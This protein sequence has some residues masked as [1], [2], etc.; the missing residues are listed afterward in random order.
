MDEN[1]GDGPLN[2]LF[3]FFGGLLVL[4]LVTALVAPSFIEWGNYRAQFE[5]Q[6]GKVLGQKVEV[7][8]EAKARLLPLPRIIFTNVRVGGSED[9]EPMMVVDRFRVD[10]ELAPLLKGEV[11]IVDMEL[12]NPKVN[13]A[14]GKD[15]VVDWTDRKTS[16]VKLEDVQLER[17]SISGG[18]I[19][20]RNIATDQSFRADDINV[21]ISARTLAGPWRING[22]LVLE[23]EK[24]DVKITT[25]R[26]HEDGLINTRLSIQPYAHPYAIELDGPIGMV[27]GTLNYKGA[28]KLKAEQPRKVLADGKPARS[29]PYVALPIRV[30][31]RFDAKPNALRVQEFKLSVGS[32][33]DPYSITGTAQ[34]AFGDR[35][36]F[37]IVAEGQQ[38]DIDRMG[39]LAKSKGNPPSL[40][41][42]LDVLRKIA[43]KVPAPPAE[44][45]ISLY[46]PAVIAGDTV[47]REVGVDIRP[48]K[49]GWQLS[50]LEAGLPG[51]TTLQ[52]NGLLTLGENFGFA[53]QLLLASRQ[54]SGFAGW[55]K[56]DVSE[57]I[58]R[59]PNAGFSANV[60]LNEKRVLLQDLEI[61]LGDT[62]LKGAFERVQHTNS[63]PLMTTILDGNNID[64]ETMQAL[65]SLFLSG[66]KGGPL[67][68]HDMDIKL[69]AENFSA[70]GIKAKAVSAALR[71]VDD[72]LTIDALTIGDLSGAE[73][74]LQGTIKD[75]FKL[76]D[77][78]MKVS[79]KAA[80]PEGVLGLVSRFAGANPLLDNLRNEPSLARDLVLDATLQASAEGGQAGLVLDLKG[81]AAGTGI[82]LEVNVDG[83]I[84]ELLTAKNTVHLTLI[85]QQPFVLLRQ[86]AVPVLPVDVAGEMRIDAGFK[87]IAGERGDVEFTVLLEDAKLSGKGEIDH[88][89][90]GNLRSRFSVAFKSGDIDPLLLLSGYAFPGMN[91]GAAVDLRGDFSTDGSIVSIRN[92]EGM[93]AGQKIDGK[94]SI[95]RAAKPRPRVAGTLSLEQVS[96]RFVAGLVMGEAATE[97]ARPWNSVAFATPVLGGFNGSI[98]LKAKM[99]D[100]ATGNFGYLQKAGNLTARLELNDGDIAVRDARFDWMGGV[101]GG[102][103]SLSQNQKEI[104]VSSQVNVTNGDLGMVTWQREG[105]PVIEGRYDLVINTEGSGSSIAGIVASLSGGGTMTIHDGTIRQLNPSSLGDILVAADK[106]SDEK[107]EKETGNLVNAALALHP[108]A[109]DKAEIAFSIAGGNLRIGNMV[110][111]TP[112]AKLSGSLRL[113]IPNWAIDGN[114]RLSFEAGEESLSGATPEID[115]AFI[116]PVSAISIKRDSSLL[117][118]FLSMRAR[119]RKER[120]YEAQ[121]EEILENQRL[122]RMVRLYKS[123]TREREKMRLAR[124]NEAKLEEQKRAEEDRL[125]KELEAAEEKAR[126]ARVAIQNKQRE[127]EEKRRQ[128]ELLKKQRQLEEARELERKKEDLKRRQDAFDKLIREKKQEEDRLRKNRKTSVAIPAPALAPPVAVQPD[129]VPVKKGPYPN[130]P[131]VFD[132]VEERI[133][134]ILK[135][136]K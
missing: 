39:K 92:M 107:L 26:V 25:G 94:L 112:G 81:E 38:I 59:L 119:E 14:I 121:K 100:L 57:A 70:F 63:R 9:G 46:L 73:I 15:G 54:P 111:S 90:K 89:K 82:D 132:N 34:A 50:N 80:N 2:R 18:S 64:L 87:G 96:L 85:N 19:R 131:G 62:Q 5:K 8:G 28:F 66:E 52:A 88:G 102:E 79:L 6:A 7:L 37:K 125:L 135:N 129:G 44:G 106:I 49:D 124:E 56:G 51:R 60:V 65:F 16:P 99:L 31:G 104:V 32:K 122:M 110:A 97:S 36:L 74:S 27:K 23:G 21:E 101:F 67:A 118:S 83:G 33:D 12:E 1:F 76:P 114:A 29:F 95:D 130:L 68:D 35:S 3:V 105:Q 69:N 98:D 133:G 11:V 84:G 128:E 40:G 78:E 103:I 61:A 108:F 55:L 30:N 120:E 72:R 126:Q 47:I 41:E 93:L 43:E 53:G 20:V 109:F 13:I 48:R 123:R 127:A 113:D 71:L 116:G 75:A 136:S 22:N 86:M 134:D 42:R 77:G 91:A 115:F 10:A 117:A 58:R 4:V 17:V 45:L 24:A